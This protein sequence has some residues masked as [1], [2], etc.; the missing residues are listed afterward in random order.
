MRAA[1][2]CDDEPVIDTTTSLPDALDFDCPRCGE[3]VAEAFYG[4]CDSCRQDLRTRMRGEA[5]A[6]EKV[7]YEPKMNVTPNHVA[8]KD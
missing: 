6:V 4:P 8:T 7:E 1:R 3:T 2:V 5:R